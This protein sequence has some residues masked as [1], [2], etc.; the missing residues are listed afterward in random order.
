[1]RWVCSD[2]M[3]QGTEVTKDYSNGF[4]AVKK[5]ANKTNAN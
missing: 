2:Q 5:K 1:M 4:L 3:A